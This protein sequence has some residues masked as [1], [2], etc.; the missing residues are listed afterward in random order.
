MSSASPEYGWVR[1][2]S[3]LW[4]L[5]SCP[6]SGAG[7]G[8]KVCFC[9]LPDLIMTGGKTVTEEGEKNRKKQTDPTSVLKIAAD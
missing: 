1:T 2:G 6:F 5:L 8:M 7:K 9:L 3:D 4:L